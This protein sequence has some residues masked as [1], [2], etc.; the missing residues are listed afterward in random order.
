MSGNGWPRLEL[1]YLAALQAVASEGSFR[2]A[3][4]RLGY[5]QSAVSQQIAALERE[6]GERVVVRP[7]GRGEVTLTDAGAVLLGHAHAISERVD[8]RTRV[9][10][11]DG[12]VAPR[13][14]GLVWHREREPGPAALAFTE[15]AR[16]VCAEL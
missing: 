6:V 14:V 15:L 11:I 10:D 3:A 1:R 7:R 4:E 12:L 2:R 13:R 9:L 5:T 8:E 16:A